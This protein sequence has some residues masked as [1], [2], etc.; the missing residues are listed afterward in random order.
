MLPPQ[1]QSQAGKGLL[2]FGAPMDLGDKAITG[3]ANED[4]GCPALSEPWFLRT[5]SLA[6]PRELW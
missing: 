2:S 4:R 1:T 5:H 3:R 6:H